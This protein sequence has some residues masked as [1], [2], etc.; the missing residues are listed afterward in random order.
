MIFTSL[1]PWRTIKAMTKVINARAGDKELAVKLPGKATQQTDKSRGIRRRRGRSVALSDNL[2][3][4]REEWSRLFQVLA[5]KSGLTSDAIAELVQNGLASKPESV[6]GSTTRD[7]VNK[8]RALKATLVP[9]QSEASI[10]YEEL[11][12]KGVFSSEDER[13]RFL[14]LWPELSPDGAARQAMLASAHRLLVHLASSYGC[15]LPTE[16]SERLSTV[17]EPGVWHLLAAL[18]TQYSFSKVANQ[19]PSK[20]VVLRTISQTWPQSRR[21]TILKRLNSRHF[22]DYL[23]HLLLDKNFEAIVAILADEETNLPTLESDTRLLQNNL[24][25]IASNSKSD[26]SSRSRLTLLRL[27]KNKARPST[28]NLPHNAV[29][30]QFFDKVDHPR[31]WSM[32]ELDFE[33]IGLKEAFDDRQP[34]LLTLAAPLSEDDCTIYEEALGDVIE[35]DAASNRWVWK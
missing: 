24:D 33:T 3:S 16:I 22:L 25:A 27:Q 23:K 20:I 28:L 18:S 14:R 34:R 19:E 2:K 30:L 15:N 26:G 32:E 6:E 1:G 35:F 12:K 11:D 9:N 10:L 17:Q 5:R 29:W 31:G 21:K 13:K 7:T 4:E 8:W